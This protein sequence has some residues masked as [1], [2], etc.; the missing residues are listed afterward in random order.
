MNCL[1]SRNSEEVWKILNDNLFNIEDKLSSM[2]IM[3][4]LHDTGFTYSCR[5]INGKNKKLYDYRLACNI[6]HNQRLLFRFYYEPQKDRKLFRSFGKFLERGHETETIE[7]EEQ[8]DEIL[9]EIIKK[10]C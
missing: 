1:Y 4:N 9:L 8:M 3:L 2:T 5:R 10:L 6:N 7:S